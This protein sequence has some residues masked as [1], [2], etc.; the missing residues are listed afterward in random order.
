M[1]PLS[2][3]KSLVT[4]RTDCMVSQHLWDVAVHCSI[5]LDRQLQKLCHQRSVIMVLRVLHFCHYKSMYLP[6]HLNSDHFYF[7]LHYCVVDVLIVNI[8]FLTHST[9]ESCYVFVVYFLLAV[10]NLNGLLWVE[11]CDAQFFAI[12]MRHNCLEMLT[13]IYWA[14]RHCV[15]IE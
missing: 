14:L 8:C 6:D 12:S 2:K 1:A 7:A 9:Q 13:I 10:S 4:A 5:A 15:F 11:S 3:Q